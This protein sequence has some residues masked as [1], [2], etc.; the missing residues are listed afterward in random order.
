MRQEYDEPVCAFGARGQANVCK[1]TQQYP[2]CKTSVDYIEAMIKV[3]LSRGL[4]DSEIQMDLLGDKKQDKTLEQVLF[5]E[6]KEA[7]PTCC[8]PRQ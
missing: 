5:V 3:V 4:E 1:F 6:A 7:D 8:C 2:G